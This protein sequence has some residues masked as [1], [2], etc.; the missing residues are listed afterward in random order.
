MINDQR[1]PRAES[2]ET[3]DEREGRKEG[4]KEEYGM[5]PHVYEIKTKE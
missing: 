2:R 5:T 4:R 1:E 3:R